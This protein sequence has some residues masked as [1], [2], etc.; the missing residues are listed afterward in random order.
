MYSR[1]TWI[2]TGHIGEFERGQV[3]TRDQIASYFRTIASEGLDGSCHASDK[4]ILEAVDDLTSGVMLNTIEEY[5][6]VEP[7]IV[8]IIEKL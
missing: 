2:A 8:E 6:G 3:L 5:E 7:E 4:I 1:D